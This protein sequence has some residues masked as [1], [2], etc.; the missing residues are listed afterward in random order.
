MARL[1]LSLVAALFLWAAAPAAA[2]SPK[3]SHVVLIVLENREYGEAIGNPEAPYLNHL[4]RRGALATNYFGITHPSLPNYLALLGGSTFGIAENCTEC[5]ARGPNLATQL[6]DAGISWRAYMGNL[7]YP[8]F[9]AASH[10]TYA[11]RHNPFVYFPSITAVPAHCRK[12]VPET[13]LL[14]DLRRHRL[15]EFGWLTPNLCDNAH[16]CSLA[17]ADSH[18]WNLA[19]RILRQLGP[20]GLLVV[21]FDEGTSDAGCCGQ[22]GGGRVATILVGPDIPRGAEI[23]QPANHYSLLAAIENRFGLPRLRHA[24]SVQPL[25]PA[26]FAA[27]D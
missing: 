24:A 23:H 4:A 2:T 6:S 9:T 13:R 8:C 20:H 1:C 7:P 22:P 10:G 16:D 18:L 3:P 12:V 11:K 5:V 15:P 27:T 17:T 19:P 21:T 26:L 25:S 14:A